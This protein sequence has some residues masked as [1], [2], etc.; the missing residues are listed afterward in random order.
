MTSSGNGADTISKYDGGLMGK[1]SE[2][3]GFGNGDAMQA[4][5]R[6][7]LRDSIL[8]RSGNRHL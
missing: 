6:S 3:A 2:R 7:E 5:S 1:L 8:F 4:E